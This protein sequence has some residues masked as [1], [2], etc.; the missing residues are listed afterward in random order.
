MRVNAPTEVKSIIQFED[1]IN[2]TN[3]KGCAFEIIYQSNIKAYFKP[4]S[5]ISTPLQLK[6]FDNTSLALLSVLNQQISPIISTRIDPRALV[7]DVRKITEMTDLIDSLFARC[8]G[9][10]DLN[11]KR[12][13]GCLIYWSDY[14][15]DSLLRDYNL[16]IF[17][18]LPYLHC[19]PVALID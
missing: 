4:C 8:G 11:K 6:N 13:K 17:H 2:N 3:S 15:E 1:K 14:V 12:I 10:N 18:L 9:R 19:H 5:V 7:Q 16:T